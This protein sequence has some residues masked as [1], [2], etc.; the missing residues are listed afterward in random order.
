MKEVFTSKSKQIYLQANSGSS[1]NVYKDESRKS[2]QG[3]N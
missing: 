3:K 1:V 2:I